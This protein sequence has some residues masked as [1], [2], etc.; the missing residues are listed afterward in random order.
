MTGQ[1]ISRQASLVEIQIMHI[2]AES[3]VKAANQIG[4]C[5]RGG[6]AAVNSHGMKSSK[7]YLQVRAAK[8]LRTQ[9]E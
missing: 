1:S 7:N 3:W 6:E 8:K 9:L 2:P 5:L 4:E